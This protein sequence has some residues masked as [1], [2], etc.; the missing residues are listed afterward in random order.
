MTFSLLDNYSSQND[1]MIIKNILSSIILLLQFDQKIGLQIFSSGYNNIL[2]SPCS[3]R[4][5]EKSMKMVEIY[6]NQRK[7]GSW[8]NYSWV[9]YKW[10]LFHAKYSEC[11][12][13]L[14][15]DYTKKL[16]KMVISVYNKENLTMVLKHV[17]MWKTA[18]ENESTGQRDGL[19]G[20][21]I[22]DRLHTNSSTNSTQDHVWSH[23]LWCVLW[24][25]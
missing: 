25:P 12:D 2:P 5:K 20:F 13:V 1:P 23:F 10:F 21:W 7:L 9:W 17:R 19:F 15:D 14:A 3:R 11:I 6:Y 18:L 16:D 8:I 4:I 24:Q 22:N